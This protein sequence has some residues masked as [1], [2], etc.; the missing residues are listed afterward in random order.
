MFQNYNYVF[1]IVNDLKLCFKA[2]R[3]LT[4]TFDLTTFYEIF[5]KP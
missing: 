1:D 3:D 2:F 5:L 4:L